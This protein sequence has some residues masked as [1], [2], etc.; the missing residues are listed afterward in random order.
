MIPAVNI[1]TYF[2]ALP[3]LQ[4]YFADNADSCPFFTYV[5]TPVASIEWQ[6]TGLVAN[7]CTTVAP[8]PICTACVPLYIASDTSSAT[9]PD[10]TTCTSV[11][12]QWWGQVSGT[13]YAGSVGSSAVVPDVT[14]TAVVTDSNGVPRIFPAANNVSAGLVTAQATTAA[15][16]T[17]TINLQ[18][19]VVIGEDQ[20]NVAVTASRV[21]YIEDT[22][23]TVL[24]SAGELVQLSDTAA[25]LYDDGSSSTQST[26]NTTTLTVTSQI[27]CPTPT[28]IHGPTSA[29]PVAQSPFAFCALLWGDGW[30]VAYSG[31][32]DTE[33]TVVGGI[34]IT[35]SNGVPY[36][37]AGWPVL[38]ISG[39][40][41]W[42]STADNSA[43]NVSFAATY[44]TAN[45]S[46]V[47]LQSAEQPLLFVYVG[48]EDYYTY[49]DKALGVGYDQP[50]TF[51][52]VISA[53]GFP[54]DTT[55]GT[56]GAILPGLTSPQSA[57]ALV[58]DP[59]SQQYREVGLSGSSIP[60]DASMLSSFTY[61]PL[62]S[63]GS[64]A[65][66]GCSATLPKPAI[67]YNETAV[68]QLEAS[69]VAWWPFDTN[70]QD[71]TG[72]VNATT[73][74]LQP[75]G[76]APVVDTS[77]SRYGNGSLYSTAY[78]QSTN[79][80]DYLTFTPVSLFTTTRTD[81]S[82]QLLSFSVACWLMLDS[83]ALPT[84]AT[85]P[86][87]ATSL[88]SANDFGL[89]LLW[90]G[91]YAF[92]TLQA[93]YPAA[94][95]AA[96]KAANVI[97]APLTGRQ[98]P[99]NQWTHVALTWSATDM[100]S[101]VVA[102]SMYVNGSLVGTSSLL[103][104]VTNLST[105]GA[106][107]TATALYLA[108]A[109][110]TATAF[111]G[112][113][114]DVMLYD[115]AL[116][117]SQVE[118]LATYGL[119]TLE[120]PTAQIGVSYLPIPS[121]TECNLTHA[122]S[123][124]VT[125]TI[126]INSSATVVTTRQGIGAGGSPLVSSSTYS[127]VSNSS[128]TWTQPWNQST[129]AG[130]FDLSPLTLFA[131]TTTSPP[132]PTTSSTTLPADWSTVA[133][134]AN[135]T[136]TFTQPA[137]NLT[138][139]IANL[140]LLGQVDSTGTQPTVPFLVD[141]NL[142][143]V[144]PTADMANLPQPVTLYLHS[145]ALNSTL[146]AVKGTLAAVVSQQAALVAAA[147][148]TSVAN[149]STLTAADNSTTTSAL[150]ANVTSNSTTR[151]PY[152][153]PYVYIGQ[154]GEQDNN[155]TNSALTTTTYLVSS[156]LVCSDTDWS[157]L[158]LVVQLGSG[159]SVSVSVTDVLV[160][161][162]IA[163]LSG[164]ANSSLF[165]NSSAPLVLTIIGATIDSPTG[166]SSYVL[167]TLTLTLAGEEAVVLPGSA[168]T[169]VLD[170]SP[171]LQCELQTLSRV[172]VLDSLVH[173]IEQISTNG[174]A[175]GLSFV[176][177]SQQV[178]GFN[179]VDQSVV[180]VSG[181]VTIAYNEVVPG[182][183]VCGMHGIVVQAFDVRDLQFSAPLYSSQPTGNDGSFTLD[184]LSN[185][186]VVLAAS[187]GGNQSLGHTF[188]PQFVNLTAADTAAS[189][190][191]VN[192]VDTTTATLTVNIVGGLCSA[193]IGSVRPV[194]VVD[195]CG[196]TH[197]P[198]NQMSWAPVPYVLPAIAARFVSYTA[199][200]ADG[201]G[202]QI[203]SSPTLAQLNYQSD[204]NAW[205]VANGQLQLNL[206]LGGLTTT[207][208]YTAPTTIAMLQPDS[209][210]PT[211]SS[212]PCTD[213]NPLTDT[214]LPFDIYPSQQPITFVW[215][216]YE[217]YGLPPNQLICGHVNTS[218]VQLWVHD[219]L[220]DDQTNP[221]V[222]FGCAISG[223][224]DPVA[225]Q[226]I[227]TYSTLLG[228][229]FPFARG[230]V[231]PPYTRDIHWGEA[232]SAND[233]EFV[234]SLLLT[235]SL[236]YGGLT[237]I[238]I[239]PKPSSV[240]LTLRDPPGGGSFTS[241]TSAF[242]VN[243]QLTYTTTAD[244]TV[245][246]SIMNAEGFEQRIGVCEGFAAGVG[247]L[248]V[249]LACNKVDENDFHNEL[250]LDSTQGATFGTT[251]TQHTSYTNT[252]TVQTSADPLTND[253][254]GDMLLIATPTIA[255]ALV[256]RVD[257]YVSPSAPG[258]CAV[259]APYDASSASFSDEQQLNWMGVWEIKHFQIPLAQRTVDSLLVQNGGQ[260]YFSNS[261]TQQAYTTAVQAVFGWQDILAQ[262]E[263][264]KA[265]AAEL[266]GL[267][268][269]LKLAP[270]YPQTVDDSS[271][272]SATPA[273]VFDDDNFPA[274]SNLLEDLTDGDTG[275]LASGVLVVSFNGAQG[276][277]AYD[278]AGEYETSSDGRS[279]TITGSG[280]V[281]DTLTSKTFLFVT[282]IALVIMGSITASGNTDSTTITESTSSYDMHI[283]LSDPD[284]GDQFDVRILQDQAGLPVFQTLSGRSSC[285]SEANT[286]AREDM[287]VSLSQ[288]EFIHQDPSGVVNFVMSLT[289]ES[290][291]QE[292]FGY[293]IWHT[294]NTNGLAF[295]FNGVDDGYGSNY[296]L[297]PPGQT[298]V[299]VSAYTSDASSY[300]PSYVRFVLQ[301]VN[302]SN[303]YYQDTTYADLLI[304]YDT[305]CSSSKFGGD[306]LG[307]SSITIG[308][309]DLGG[310]PSDYQFTFTIDNPNA[311]SGDTW[312]ANAERDSGFS[313]TVQW[314]LDSDPD[315]DAFW[316]TLP[317]AN[318]AVFD[319]ITPAVQQAEQSSVA[320]PEQYQFVA[321]LPW[322]AAGTYDLR[323]I[324]QCTQPAAFQGNPMP[325]YETISPIVQVEFDP[326][327]PQLVG[328]AEPF[329]QRAVQLG[330]EWPLWAPGDFIGAT[331]SEPI[332]C[333]ASDF[334]V[335]MSEASSWAEL[336]DVTFIPTPLPTPTWLCEGSELRV[337]FG[338]PNWAQLS[339]S[340]VMVSVSGLTDAV[341][342]V[343][344]PNT[345]Y[346]AFQVLPFNTTDTTFRFQ[347]LSLRSTL[348]E[349]QQWLDSAERRAMH[350]MGVGQL[351]SAAAVPISPHVL[352]MASFQQ[353]LVKRL[354]HN[355]DRR[356][357]A[358][359]VVDGQLQREVVRLL[360]L[361]L[362]AMDVPC[363][364]QVEQ[365]VVQHNRPPAASIADERLEGVELLLL[366]LSNI[367]TAAGVGSVYESSGS[368][369]PP[370]MC[371]T[372]AA[373]R[374][375]HDCFMSEACR[376]ELDRSRFPLLSQLLL[377]DSFAQKRGNSSVEHR[378]LSPA[379]L[380]PFSFRPT[381]DE[382]QLQLAGAEFS[383]RR[384]R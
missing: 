235:G 45:E 121:Y 359:S 241:W 322:S 213:V 180:T 367:T 159:V 227:V 350:M 145:T 120:K 1:S 10:I 317:L 61:V 220:S 77:V 152:V 170:A 144:P 66:M 239:P 57:F 46:A 295:A 280:K 35:S 214:G 297:L 161:Y 78:N 113:L 139:V 316:T 275:H 40:R 300:G 344:S 341:G 201:S 218:L 383:L 238:K 20:L 245:E 128:V 224:F 271:A 294:I 338:S 75:S 264:Q 221:C 175:T 348:S 258:G 87:V 21:D 23:R 187:F 25:V 22:S 164:S 365:V 357:Q 303:P 287:A 370:Q 32:I 331:W 124:N 298:E 267:V 217:L 309:A 211:S 92:A 340:F 86:L 12:V 74:V 39:T 80:A 364:W 38:S 265:A 9:E 55:V 44:S 362:T 269:S 368:Q 273:A 60:A 97:S 215:R 274:A 43:Q 253:G 324:N 346:W 41:Q 199:E 263:A 289:N 358:L 327:L 99:T 34:N 190:A 250:L 375:L 72:R 314:K 366:P 16:G 182:I 100:S 118:Q 171:P 301:G 142:Q 168:S 242:A 90:N 137:L 47:G 351:E 194:L 363:H 228:D 69:L 36:S 130:K 219:Q 377:T 332:D 343:Q 178:S 64:V 256:T 232:D 5:S 369:Q 181:R 104:S 272:T 268:N 248:E 249:S 345:L 379:A 33:T 156:E 251:Y 233:E 307:V 129:L 352:Y 82:I 283:E 29:Q 197:F 101:G 11:A 146:T 79:Q 257:A 105:P 337:G 18:T 83:T 169:I 56:S 296:Y 17:Y 229:P 319:P 371:S 333:S 191:G 186:P 167:D 50:S 329:M 323:V 335:T 230:S 73:S 225:G 31:V 266:G 192:F 255:I 176:S 117:P 243:A 158:Q 85:M 166:S 53:A 93:H 28:F 147:A 193:P 54:V 347:T 279:K 308:Q 6:M 216:L 336:A 140:R 183:E 330:S 278:L 354:E 260:P 173:S 7:Y 89:S 286:V 284:I 141:G 270:T 13:V 204:V 246:E 2:P 68:S 315:T 8:Q 305:P 148:A 114:D 48:L 293:T 111:A 252:F 276:T 261:Q 115:N 291:F 281:Q 177:Y 203:P 318:S 63:I 84:L 172:T 212:V 373:A 226:T 277:M 155:V 384:R 4:T 135:V 302:C 231:A 109:P 244:V 353:Q 195:S 160:G 165:T 122:T 320:L 222:E 196:S 157:T 262:N 71:V 119:P 15:D 380:P 202:L 282:K 292:S 98:L 237:T 339:G 136:S 285:G 102:V 132:A 26:I 198:L 70:E 311:L 67:A 376:N 378:W 106:V 143:W 30:A 131:S 290:P 223:V 125:A 149:A 65:A 374:R 247:V 103:V 58:Y 151:P 210:S 126:T 138:T 95:S 361:Q 96:S 81:G 19:P 94:L 91:T 356:A 328:D 360:D 381:L 127:S 254:D 304:N 153:N 209:I 133:H 88:G 326:N 24:S 355:L 349:A 310:S 207:F 179:F 123:I 205:L 259:R 236:E 382:R 184:V 163:N 14:V 107:Q 321:T 372:E 51:A 108:G 189:I 3:L 313:I 162:T 240:L 37:G 288:S 325:L 150:L 110:G 206:T 188:S 76:V 312:A 306:L 334:L 59:T 62:A 200:S 174:N 134:A 154:Q 208:V 342:N 27:I 42:V 112:W 49:T 234:L 52:H 116:T 299:I 185:Q